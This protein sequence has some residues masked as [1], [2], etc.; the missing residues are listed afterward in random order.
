MF[1]LSGTSISIESSVEE[2]ANDT[3]SDSDA[4][5]GVASAGSAGWD[6]AMDTI[7]TK[8]DT[9]LRYHFLHYTSESSA[10]HTQICRVQER[11]RQVRAASPFGKLAG[12]RLISFIVK[13]DDDLRQEQLA[14]Q[15]IDEFSQEFSALYAAASWP[16]LVCA[17]LICSCR[18]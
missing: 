9:N 5:D 2:D 8:V 17:I 14:M 18:F 4:D 15:L 1:L 6:G 16:L 7:S 12:W 11:E 13:A 10:I 3:Q